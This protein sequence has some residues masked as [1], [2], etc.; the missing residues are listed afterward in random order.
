MPSQTRE[1][2]SDLDLASFLVAR[3]ARLIQVVPTPDPRRF[4]F[5][6]EGDEHRIEAETRS[7]LRGEA[8]I[9][10]RAFSAARRA[11]ARSLAGR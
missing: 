5:V 7:F 4:D 9:D 1:R 11:L 8:R 2:T 3:G 6:L 10:P